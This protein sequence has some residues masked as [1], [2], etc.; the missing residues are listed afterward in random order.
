MMNM[1]LSRW[2]AVAGAALLLVPIL[3]ACGNAPSASPAA[4]APTS[5]PV[6]TATDGATIVPAPTAAVPAPTAAPSA[7]APADLSKVAPRPFD[8][9]MQTEERRVGKE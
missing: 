3:A 2:L 1:K 4:G 8:Q 9:A 7:P 5:A 6:T